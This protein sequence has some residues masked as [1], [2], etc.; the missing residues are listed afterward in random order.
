MFDQNQNQKRFAVSGFIIAM[1][2]AAVT[3]LVV[4]FSFISWLF[5]MES[6]TV[7]PGE[8]AVLVDRPYFFG[9][10]GV[11][12]EVLREGRELIWVTT[13]AI[14]V[15]KLPESKP[16][17]LDDFSSSDN[18][19]LDFET[20][21]QLRVVDSRDLIQNFGAEWFNNNVRPQYISI[22]REA[23]KKRSMSDMMSNPAVAA[24]VDAEVTRGLEQLI[25]TN[26]IPVQI[27]NVAMGRAKP[28]K[29]V[30]DQMNETAAQQQRNKT[31]IAATAAEVQRKEEQKAKAEAD[32]AYRMEM[33]LDTREFVQLQT[34]K[35]YADA[36]KEAKNCVFSANGQSPVMVNAVK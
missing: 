26:R 1:V 20:S 9:Q 19:L 6:V 7:Q 10:E 35:I 13:D 2:L 33:K 23:V 28:N 5:F 14:K 3:V 29:S 18:I 15:N 12:K 34:A 22:V 21:I 32:N 27:I 24:Q 4:A 25:R 11:R 16:V 17:P 8:E 30:L 36:C 31:L